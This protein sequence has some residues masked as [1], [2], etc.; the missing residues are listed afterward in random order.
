M[1]LP[2]L[3]AMQE[4]ESEIPTFGANVLANISFQSQIT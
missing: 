4:T 3:Q 1:N 2:I